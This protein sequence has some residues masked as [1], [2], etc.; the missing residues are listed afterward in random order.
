MMTTCMYQSLLSASVS[1][2]LCTRNQG[3]EAVISQSAQK[4]KY[5]LNVLNDDFLVS[6]T[7]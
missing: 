6:E 5:S 2:F 1:T 4:L 7:Q 3:P